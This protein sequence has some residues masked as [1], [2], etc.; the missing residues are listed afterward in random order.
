MHV[1]MW[2]LAAIVIVIVS[3]LMYR[4]LAPQ[5]WKEWGRTGVVQAF[6]IAFY[7][8]MYGFPLTI[9][10]LSR[11][12][13]L[14]L[15]WAQGGNLWAQLF[16][17]P[18]AHIV[19]MA[20]GYAIVFSGATLVAEGWRRVHRAR[21]EE[22]LVTD[23]VY[24]RVRHPQYTGLFVIVFGE[25]IMHWPTIVSVVAFPVIVLAYTLLAQK[26]ELQML[27][28]FGDQYR[29]YQRRVPGF[30]PRF[31]SGDRQET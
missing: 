1:G 22:R 26:E 29:E 18:I 14:D 3:W 4:Y 5:S 21:R 2:G 20:I 10:F 23:G 27:E 24:A 15:A 25:G 13:G 30:I 12:F 28:M 19:A 11:F 8:E 6:I 17:T 31:G 7:A 9:Y 16:G